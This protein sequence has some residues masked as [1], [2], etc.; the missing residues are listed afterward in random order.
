MVNVDDRFCIDRYEGTLVDDATGKALS[1]HYPPEPGVAQ[2]MADKWRQVPAS[3]S[4]DAA[5]G[6]PLPPLP[7][8]EQTETFAPRAVNR[9]GVIPQG[10]TSGRVAAQACARAGKRLCTRE[11]WV[12]ACRGE[13]Q[14]RFP[15]GDVYRPGQ[16]NVFR[17]EH[18]AKILHGNASIGHSDPRLGLVEGRDGPLLRRTGATRTC[19]SRWAR[20]AIY[21]MVGNIDEWIDAPEGM[22][23]GGFFSRGTREGCDSA[24]SAHPFKY[25]DY[26]TGVRC[27]R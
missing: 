24:V 20:D 17:S 8:I 2:R 14:R 9:R 4:T 3:E 26:S 12:F 27:C 1:P 22:F 6:M 18:P 13:K 11:E 7:A 15:Y 21:D 5:A 25:W 23:V 19:A 10:Y 16:C